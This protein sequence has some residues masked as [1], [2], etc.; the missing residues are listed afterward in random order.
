MLSL[1]L[2]LT[3]SKPHGYAVISSECA[4]TLTGTVAARSTRVRERQAEE[5]RAAAVGSEVGA[6]EPQAARVGQ[7]VAG[8]ALAAVEGRRRADRLD[9]DAEPDAVGELQRRRPDAAHLARDVPA[10]GVEA[11]VLEARGIRARPGG[12]LAPVVEAC[13]D[14]EL[15]GGGVRD[16]R[17]E[18]EGRDGGEDDPVA[19]GGL[20]P[21]PTSADTGRAH[22]VRRRTRRGRPDP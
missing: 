4:S 14:G 12:D 3:P 20:A 2:G 15:R 9:A 6:R 10:V 5:R 1:A 8:V 11:A 19:H 16:G 17:Q 22:R 21:F 13:G 18:R 7:V